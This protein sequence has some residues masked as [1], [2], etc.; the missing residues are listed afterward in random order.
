MNGKNRALLSGQYIELPEGV[1]RYQLDGPEDGPVVVLVHG[2][3]GHYMIWDR[4]FPAL[5]EAGFRV[6]R[7]D[8]YGRGYSDRPFV[9]YNLGLYIKQL[10]DLLA[11]L[12]ISEPV[13][14]VGLSMGGIVS[15]NFAVHFAGKVRSLTLIDPAGFRLPRFWMMK[16]LAL[17]VVGEL[18]FGIFPSYGLLN[19]MANHYFSEGAVEQLRE[20]F[21]LQMQYKGFRRSLLSTIR[22]GALDNALPTYRKVG[23]QGLPVQLFWGCDDAAVP[24]RMSRKLLSVIPQAD[25]I[26]IE[27]AGHFPHHEQ[28]EIVN[29]ALI[30]FLRSGGERV[31]AELAREV[32]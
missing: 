17:P 30:E 25:L 24:F 23:K 19:R 32:V 2:F 21:E 14:L 3:L 4:T 15:A 31:R 10:N 5:V 20:Q 27:G 13:H 26:T 29:P 8:L 12:E 9:R 18:I 7:Y 6:L 11:A 16:G 22:C 1:V 28:P